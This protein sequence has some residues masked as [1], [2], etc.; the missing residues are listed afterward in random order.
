MGKASSTYTQQREDIKTNSTYTTKSHSR[1]ILIR[2][3]RH[4]QHLR[5]NAL[6]NLPIIPFPLLLLPICQTPHIAILPHARQRQQVLG[7]P[8]LPAPVPVLAHPLPDRRAPRALGP[9]PLAIPRRAHDPGAIRTAEGLEAALGHDAFGAVHAVFV[10]NA[11]GQGGLGALEEGP[12]VAAG[13]GRAADGNRARDEGGEHGGPVVGLLGGHGKADDGVEGGDAQVVGEQ[14]VLG[15]DAVAVVWLGEVGGVGGG[16]GFAVGEHGDDDDVV[17]G[18]AAGGEVLRRVDAS[19]VAG[20][21]ED[22]FGGGGVEGAVGD[23]DGEG[24]ARV[25]FEGG[26]RVGGDAG[27]VVGFGGRHGGGWTGDCVGVWSGRGALI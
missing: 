4:H 27:L 16:G 3:A 22:G 24:G 11:V 25:E 23:E 19:A 20:G 17:G 2:P 10:V 13:L 15:A 6:Q 8:A 5:L 12:I 1:K 26:D 9:P 14:G 21:D 7:V 18:E